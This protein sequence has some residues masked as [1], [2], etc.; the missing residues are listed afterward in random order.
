MRLVPLI[1]GRFALPRMRVWQ[2][3]YPAQLAQDEYSDEEQERRQA[4][5]P[6]ATE[7]EVE[8]ESDVVEERDPAQ[9]GLEAD[10]RT[11]RG[12]DEDVAGGKAPLGRPPVVLVLPR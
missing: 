9:A 5:Q 3:E 7:L 11:A 12:G 10:L 8:V 1:A 4:Q 6:K 2:I